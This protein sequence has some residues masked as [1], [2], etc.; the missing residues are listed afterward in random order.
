MAQQ[1][2]LDLDGVKSGPY[3]TPEVLGLIAEGEVLPHH[4]ISIELKDA[5]WETV[6][7]WRLKQARIGAQPA[8]EKKSFIPVNPEL[9]RTSP[10][11]DSRRPSYEIPWN[12]PD[13]T[14]EPTATAAPVAVNPSDEVRPVDLNAEASVDEIQEVIEALQVPAP[15]EPESP[16]AVKLE[17]LESP[18]EP[19]P[20]P[21]PP[22]IQAATPEEKPK[23]RDPMAEMFDLVQTSK[24]KREAKE[25]KHAE[26]H[27]RA[28]ESYSTSQTE[29]TGRGKMI[30]LA[31]AVVIA[32]FLLGQWYQQKSETP[33]TTVT[34]R[35]ITP[36][37]TE[38]SPAT[39]IEDRSTDKMTIRA[40]VQK[41]AVAIPTL[42]PVVGRPNARNAAPAVP[43]LNEKEMQE[44]K[45]LK[46]ELQELKA[47]K[48]ELK[49][50]GGSPMMTDEEAAAI[51]DEDYLNGP[52]QGEPGS[53]GGA[54]YS[55]PG[56][57]GF[58]NKQ[59]NYIID[60]PNAQP[61][62]PVNY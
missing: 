41:P 13:R 32:G 42:P 62:P 34:E 27:Q 52:G 9:D 25:R 59:Q 39:V 31:A 29:S 61:T 16:V 60:N 28:D 18:T 43:Q 48:E 54:G 5:P 4:R 10:K 14:A 22:P 47:L 23:K 33:D 38:P 3:Q 35:N 19:T 36:A 12:G 57:D 26:H 46:Q 56:M 11:E 37:R 17:K 45:D 50:N 1:W 51:P 2:F 44:L 55:E 24:Q 49:S 7:D 40:E 6:L 21:T 30:A 8:P 20:T 53:E 58:N 15:L